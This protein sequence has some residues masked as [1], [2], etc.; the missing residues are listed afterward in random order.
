VIELY[1]ETDEN[2]KNLRKAKEESKNE[3]GVPLYK[4]VE[5]LKLR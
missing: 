5:D 4:I 2:L 1:L 3:K